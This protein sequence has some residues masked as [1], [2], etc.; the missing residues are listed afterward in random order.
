MKK[1][2]IIALVVIGVIVLLVMGTCNFYVRTRNSL[3]QL[4]ESVS[5]SW[6][7]VENQYQRRFDLIPNLVSSVKGAAEH[8]KDVFTD[9]ANAR[10]QA[11]GVMQMSDDLLNNPE[12]FKRFQEA[13]NSLGSALQRLLV[14]TENYPQLQANENFLQLQ[15]QLEGTENRIA[16]ERK[17]FNDTVQIYNREIRMIP[18]SFIANSMGLKQKSYFSATAEATVAPKVSF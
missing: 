5:A 10:A 11:G 17:R 13:Q 4:E 14:V 9:V 18:K 3:V 12:A 8:E 6:A 16:V 7:Q 15:N 2:G 1:S